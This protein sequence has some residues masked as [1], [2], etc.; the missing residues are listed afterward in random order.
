M[1]ALILLLPLSAGCF[2]G[3][4]HGHGHGHAREHEEL[5]AEITAENAESVLEKSLRR[6]GSSAL[7]D[8]VVYLPWRQEVG[9]KP[10]LLGIE[11]QTT[12]GGP[13]GAWTRI[14]FS[15]LRKIVVTPPAQGG[16]KLWELT[17]E[18]ETQS[19]SGA[20]QYGESS[21]PVTIVTADG[22]AVKAL[23]TAV[24]VIRNTRKGPP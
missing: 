21:T 4:D 11:K 20:S 18:G 16:L 12:R 9:G 15:K 22:A 7:G 3:D 8:G 17:F 14:R 5:P 19:G 6:V 2:F 24:E 13:D 1:R 10:V 23:A